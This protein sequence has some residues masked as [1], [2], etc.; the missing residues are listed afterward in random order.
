L[1]P[2]EVLA[3]KTRKP[4]AWLRMLRG[5][6][7]SPLTNIFLGLGLIVI[8]FLEILEDFFVELATVLELHHAVLLFGI[9]T[10]LKGLTEFVEGLEIF[11]YGIESKANAKRPADQ[12]P[13]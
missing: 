5:I 4:P 11:E 12:G 8:A 9:V 7:D 2:K 13:V 3:L 6:K 1:S 10:G